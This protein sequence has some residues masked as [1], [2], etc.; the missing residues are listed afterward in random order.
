MGNMGNNAESPGLNPELLHFLKLPASYPQVPE[1]VQHIQTHISHVF[2]APPFVYKFK[3]PV[4]FGFLD[5]SSLEKRRKFCRREVELNR[6]LTDD[7]Y[8]G[9]VGVTARQGS[10]VIGSVNEELDSDRI[11]EYAVKMRKLSEKYFLHSYIDDDKL[12]EQHLDRIAEKLARFYSDQQG[13]EKLARWGAIEKVKVNTD[14]NFEQTKRFIDKTIDQ[15]TFKTIRF[16][17]NE[18]YKRNEELFRRRRDLGYMVDGHGDLHLEH[19]YITPDEVMIYDCIE[20][21]DR[22]R[23]GDLAVDLAF[24]AMDLDFNG[25]E[26]EERYLIGRMAEKL[27]DEELLR[28]INFYK[29]YRAYVKGKVKSLQSTEEEVPEEE[30]KEAAELASR[31]FKLSLRYALLGSEAKVL[32]FMGRVGTG[33]ST[34][35]KH[36][37]D[38]LNIERFSS[39]QIRKAAADQPLRERT[40]AAKRETLYS[41]QRSEQV[42]ATLREKAVVDAGSVLLDATFSNRGER[43]QLTDKLE[44]EK[45]DYIFVEAQA[46]DATIKERLKSREGEREVISDARLEDFD[47]L[48]DAY[49]SPSEIPKQHLLQINTN[50]KVASGIRE[51]YKALAEQNLKS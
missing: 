24:L 14:E 1:E 29:C 10:Y 6:R 51:L 13:E 20:F 39:D 37:A 43:K 46:P 31:Y 4:D 5:Y 40:P 50:Q 21:N 42:Y 28:I 8:L 47:K 23:Y 25:R 35:S 38:Q 16:Y 15:R 9:V 32:I 30:R 11:V 12:T 18:Y 27:A 2:I 26:Q 36:L 7:I 3:K 22:F 41:K 34:L 49:D 45:I 44:S 19:I 48:N 17:T 33:K